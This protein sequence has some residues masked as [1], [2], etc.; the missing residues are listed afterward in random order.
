MH[1][2]Y[3]GYNISIIVFVRWA[4]N[5]ELVIQKLLEHGSVEDQHTSSERGVQ[6][7]IATCRV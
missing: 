2:G 5:T 1:N 3:N 6:R 4:A 7:E